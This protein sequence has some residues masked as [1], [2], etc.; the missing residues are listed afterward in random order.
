[1]ELLY[2][3]SKKRTSQFPKIS[4]YCPD[5]QVIGCLFSSTKYETSEY[6]ERF[7]IV[8]LWSPTFNTTP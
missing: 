3:S 7:F 1:M 6:P 2:Y 4:F 5:G 8:L